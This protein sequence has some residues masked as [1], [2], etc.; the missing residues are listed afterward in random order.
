MQ[1][2]KKKIASTDTTTFGFGGTPA[3]SRFEGEGEILRLGDPIL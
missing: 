3:L 2:R 1:E